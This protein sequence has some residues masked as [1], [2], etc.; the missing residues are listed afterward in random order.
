[1]FIIVEEN[2]M[3]RIKGMVDRAAFVK[4]KNIFRQKIATIV[5]TIIAIEKSTIQLL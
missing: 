5:T 3:R 2:K 4:E 1:M